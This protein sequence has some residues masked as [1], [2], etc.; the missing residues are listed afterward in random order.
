MSVA[1]PAPDTIHEITAANAPAT[2][3]SQQTPFYVSLP[4][5]KALVINAVRFYTVKIIADYFHVSDVT[6]Y[7]LINEGHIFAVKN[8]L[9]NQWLISEGV[10]GSLVERLKAK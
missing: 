7:R 3:E 10:F 5:T 1:K 8:P 4:K 9:R 6:I 2:P